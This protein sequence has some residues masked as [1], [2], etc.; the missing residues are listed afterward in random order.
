MV[1]RFVCQRDPARDG[2]EPDRRAIRFVLRSWNCIR[3]DRRRSEGQV[4]GSRDEDRSHRGPAD[5]GSSSMI[6]SD[7]RRLATPTRVTLAGVLTDHVVNGAWWP[8]SPSVARELSGLMEAICDRL[9]HVVEISVN[10][11]AIDGVIDLDSLTRR[12]IDVIPGWKKRRQRVMTVSG[13]LARANLLVVPCATSTALAVMV[14]RRAA[15]LPVFPSHMESAAYRAAD[16]IVRAAQAECGRSK[17]GADQA[18]PVQPV[19][20]L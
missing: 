14:L 17:S 18:T 19:S 3:L 12:G 20:S 11:S 16:E 1:N 9:G 10:W 7:P 5:F 13:S 4:H 6:P 8:H 2:A 15:C